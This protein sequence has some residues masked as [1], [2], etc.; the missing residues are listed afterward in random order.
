MLLFSESSGN[1]IMAIVVKKK[2]VKGLWVEVVL[3]IGSASMGRLEVY[4]IFFFSAVL[5]GL[6]RAIAS[7][8]FVS[9]SMNFPVS[10]AVCIFLLGHLSY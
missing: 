4:L 3:C 5:L 6:M 7:A 9:E 2:R 1:H 10:Y 8:C